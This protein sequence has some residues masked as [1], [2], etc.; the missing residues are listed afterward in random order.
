MVPHGLRRRRARPR[1]RRRAG[2]RPGSAARRDRRRCRRGRSRGRARAGRG[3]RLAGPGRS[4][5]WLPSASSGH[6]GRLRRPAAP[7]RLRRRSHPDRGAPAGPP[8]RF[9]AAGTVV[10]GVERRAGAGDVVGRMGRSRGDGRTPRR[11][12]SRAGLPR[13][14]RPVAGRRPDT[15]G[16]PLAAGRGARPGRDRR[17]ACRRGPTDRTRARPRA[18]R[19]RPR[20]SD[21]GVVVVDAGAG[22]GVVRGPARRC[23]PSRQPRRQRDRR[24]RLHRGGGGAGLG[25]PDVPPH[26]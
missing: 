2:D 21:A 10:G 19:R 23:A 8:A 4:P 12:R 17:R 15:V 1:R 25:G 6:R 22:R 3:C 16:S 26:R 11:G 5:V 14:V 13:P 18:G 9:E 7:S 20:R 24:G